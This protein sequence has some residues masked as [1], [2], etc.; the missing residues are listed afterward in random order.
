MKTLGLT[1]GVGMG[2]STAETILRGWG[3]PTIDTDILGR[4]LV[5]PGQPA[6]REI[7]ARF[8]NSVLDEAGHLKRNRLA[9]IVFQ[10]ET[11]RKDLENLLHPRIRALWTAQILKFRNQNSRAVTVIIPL[12][13]EIAAESE[14]DATICLACSTQSQWARLRVRGWT[15]TQI[16]QRIAAQWPIE[17]KIARADFMI[18][19]ESSLEVTAEQLRRV[20]D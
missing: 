16:K 13:F 19:N 12:L 9:E 3:I 15:D 14:F 18:W 5:E 10:D 8:G 20:V 11:A 4:E 7:Q 2:K 17:R 1:G 6:L